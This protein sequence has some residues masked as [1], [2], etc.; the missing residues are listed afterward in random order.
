M[1]MEDRKIS[2]IFDSTK[3]T[4]H[5]SMIFRFRMLCDEDDYFLREYEVPYDM[6][7][8]DFRE[9]IDR[10]VHYRSDSITS[11]FTADSQWNKLEEFT[12]VDMN[13]D[14]TDAE[15]PRVMSDTLLSQI[16]HNNRDRL[17]YCFDLFGD[18][19]YYLELTGA[20]EADPQASYP[21]EIYAV[22]EAPDQY[23]P[24]KNRDEEDE[25]SA[26]EEMMGDFSDFEGDDNY[27]DEY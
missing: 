17:I 6:T 14:E 27:D 15:G 26:F 9:F 8:S 11:F 1:N 2:R 25:G 3:N 4:Q 13:M 18:R 23:D 16:L 22:A 20:Y 10:D 24:T 21:R 19:A 12:S 7:L 5:M